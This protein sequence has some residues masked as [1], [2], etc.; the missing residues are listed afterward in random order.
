M[1]SD[2]RCVVIATID[3]EK[4]LYIV[5]KDAMC[6]DRL[7]IDYTSKYAPTVE[8]IVRMLRKAFGW[9]EDDRGTKEVHNT[10]CSL[11][12]NG[13]CNKENK[14]KCTE[15]IRLSCKLYSPKYS[16]PITVNFIIIE[17]VGQIRNL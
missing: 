15:Q 12:D 8:Y 16:T 3:Y 9:V 17:K 4:A 13:F 7:E 11:N 6:F 2:D 14:K 5:A 1:E 10:K